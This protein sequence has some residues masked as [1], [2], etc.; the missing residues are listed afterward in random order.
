LGAD[1]GGQAL[2]GQLLRA[3]ITFDKRLR[4]NLGA[5]DEE[6]LRR[7][8]RQLQDNVAEHDLPPER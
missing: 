4:T 5:D 1:A 8:L 6:T 7:L 3:V 2:H